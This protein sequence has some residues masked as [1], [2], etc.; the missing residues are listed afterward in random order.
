MARGSSQ[1]DADLGVMSGA[2]APGVNKYSAMMQTIKTTQ[3]NYMNN[4]NNE[5]TKVQTLGASVYPCR[6]RG[7]P[8]LASHAR[9]YGNYAGL[10]RV[11][12]I[13]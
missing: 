3:H 2:S 6:S 5:I 8:R 4:K 10:S 1:Y 9:K 11:R 7:I 12:N 13:G